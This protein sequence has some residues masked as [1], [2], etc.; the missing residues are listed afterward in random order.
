MAEGRKPTV[1]CIKILT[2]DDFSL[3]SSKN[4]PYGS[5]C[6]NRKR[7]KSTRMAVETLFIIAKF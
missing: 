4:L 6:L 1:L 3:S 7:Y 5:N 2:M